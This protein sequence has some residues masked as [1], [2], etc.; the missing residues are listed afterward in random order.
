MRPPDFGGWWSI[1]PVK[2]AIMPTGGARLIPERPSL[3]AG[4][5]ADH[6]AERAEALL[7]KPVDLPP[8]WMGATEVMLRLAGPPHPRDLQDQIYSDS[9]VK[10]WQSWVKGTPLPPG[11]ELPAPKRNRAKEEA[12]EK[13]ALVPV[14]KMAASGKFEMRGKRVE[15]RHGVNVLGKRAGELKEGAPEYRQIDSDLF[16]PDALYAS[17]TNIAIV[18][19]TETA[20][21][22]L[23]AGPGQ[24]Y[25]NACGHVLTGGG[26]GVY[27]DVQFLREEVEAYLAAVG[28][29][30]VGELSPQPQAAGPS[31]SS[32]PQVN[33][34]TPEAPL[35][36][37][38]VTAKKSRKRTATLVKPL[39]RALIEV[40][41]ERK[42]DIHAA[43][44]DDLRAEATSRAHLEKRGTSNSTWHRAVS[45]ARKLS[46]KT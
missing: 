15:D 13:I 36:G 1:R 27:S 39:A 12:W 7:G 32:E 11:S 28:G 2:S 23:L 43:T 34:T 3:R 24:H 8:K 40:A 45:Q 42:Y 25:I 21:F 38:D 31:I 17:R 44:V 5:P 37:V 18:D 46:E 35:A 4:C 14:N 6:P 33:T 16:Q 10:A 26:N 29:T 30:A 41:A 20:L 22:S 19:L 9:K